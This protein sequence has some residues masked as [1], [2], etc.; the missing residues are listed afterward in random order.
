MDFSNKSKT[1]LIDEIN[2]LT[3][4]VNQLNN[5]KII[6]END[7]NNSTNTL[8]DYKSFINK[9]SDVND[10]FVNKLDDNGLKEEIYKIQ[11]NLIQWKQTEDALKV[12]EERFRIIAGLVSDFLSQADTLYF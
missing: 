8:Q 10:L 3:E 11:E 7:L 6:L 4:R 1:E 12:N 5:D 2:R 9:F